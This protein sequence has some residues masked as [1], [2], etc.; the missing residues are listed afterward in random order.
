MLS[1]SSYFVNKFAIFRQSIIFSSL[2]L[3]TA[4]DEAADAI[5]ISGGGGDELL[6]DVWCV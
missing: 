6:P 4:E 1:T 3:A 2:S 5:G